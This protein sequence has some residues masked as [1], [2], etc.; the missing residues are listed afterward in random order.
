MLSK[1]YFT[2]KQIKTDFILNS[3]MA[4]LGVIDLTR[5]HKEWQVPLII[6]SQK[7]PNNQNILNLFKKMSF[8]QEYEQTLLKNPHIWF[9]LSENRLFYCCVEINEQQSEKYIQDLQ[10]VG[11]I[12]EPLRIANLIAKA[13]I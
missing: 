2:E 11:Q 3:I 9:N 4:G 7:E 12:P 13:I 1:Q 6:I 8:D 5:L 10:L